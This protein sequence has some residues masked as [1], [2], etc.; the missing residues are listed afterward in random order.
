MD[1][2]QVARSSAALQS[3]T[4]RASY[5]ILRAKR[6]SAEQH[7]RRPADAKGVMELGLCQPLVHMGALKLG[8]KPLVD[9]LSRKG[10]DHGLEVSVLKYTPI[11]KT[12]FANEFV[13]SANPLFI[14]P[15]MG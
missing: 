10:I 12:N 6:T 2:L 7:L 1:H 15:R 8:D 14:A 3:R 11:S 13:P 5:G 9:P 4:R